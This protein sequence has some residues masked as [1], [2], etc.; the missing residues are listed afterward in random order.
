MDNKVMSVRLPEEVNKWLDDT[1]RNCGVSKS[2]LARNFIIAE[3]TTHKEMSIKLIK[4]QEKRKAST[5]ARQIQ[6]TRKENNSNLH[7]ENN[8]NINTSEKKQKVGRNEPCPCGSGKKYK[9]CCGL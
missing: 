4:E 7:N 3:Y 1:A 2:V 6:P 8:K 5:K 9:K